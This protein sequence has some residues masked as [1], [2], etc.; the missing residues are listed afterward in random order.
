L[1]DLGSNDVGVSFP[2]VGRTL[3]ARLRLHGNAESL[4]RLLSLNWLV[5]MRDHLQI[6]ELAPVPTA[7]KYRCVSRVQVDSNPERARRRLMRRHDVDAK[8]AARRIPDSAAKQ[9][10]LPFVVL[11]SN[12]SG[13][14]FRLFIRHGSLQD[15]PRQGGFG[16]YGLSADVTIPWF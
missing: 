7:A 2:D 10:D 4:D 14:S 8:E 9:C 12:G 5:G 11:R 3:G 1:Y 13:H 15:S 16:S 6:G